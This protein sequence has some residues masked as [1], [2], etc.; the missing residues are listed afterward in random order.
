MSNDLEK[1]SAHVKNGQLS[2]RDFLRTATAMGIAAPFASALLS[3]N[4]LAAH[5][6]PKCTRC[7]NT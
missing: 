1:L 3:Q 7:T 2:R 6:K 5:F 4:V